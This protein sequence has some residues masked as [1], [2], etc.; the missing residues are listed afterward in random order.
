VFELVT[1]TGPLEDA[2]QRHVLG[3]NQSPHRCL[4][5]LYCGTLVA[6]SRSTMRIAGPRVDVQLHL[7]FGDQL[8]RVMSVA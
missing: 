6:P 7:R 1:A 5:F 4:T 3:C 2:V 8:H